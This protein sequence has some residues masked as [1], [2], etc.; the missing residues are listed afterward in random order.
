MDTSRRPRVPSAHVSGPVGFGVA[1]PTFT[2]DARATFL[3]GVYWQVPI[4]VGW[5]AHVVAG[6]AATRVSQPAFHKVGQV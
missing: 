6:S 3:I 1:S 2:P 4:C 5:P